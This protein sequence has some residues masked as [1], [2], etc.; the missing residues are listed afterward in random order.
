MSFVQYLV[1]F[2]FSSFFLV[3][4]SEP[5]LQESYK[6]IAERSIS[7]EKQY[8]L[9]KSAYSYG[10]YESAINIYESLLLTEGIEDSN[11]YKD[12]LYFFLVKAYVGNRDFYSA[13]ST[14][15]EISETWREDKYYLYNLITHYVL[16]YKQSKK[17]LL[18]LLTTNLSQIRVKN[19]NDEDK[20][21]YYYFR[22]TE[23]LIKG[24]KGDFK[25]ALFQAEVFS[26]SDDER[27]AFFESLILRLDYNIEI[28]SLQTTKQLR[29]LLEANEN[30]RQAYF[31]AYDYAFLLSLRDEKDQAIEVI[32]QELLKGESVYSL[33]ELDN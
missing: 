32:N 9:A 12:E 25:N 14:L 5:T 10:L 13:K 26:E 7:L 17:D 33:Y 15:L 28:P 2:I 6:N 3:A 16:D 21:W 8:E 24:K 19:L 20:A 4:K 11:I 18:N 1:L 23:E 22:A 29:K 27:R 30:E 31:Y